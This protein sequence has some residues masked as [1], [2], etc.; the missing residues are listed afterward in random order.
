MDTRYMFK[1]SEKEDIITDI[2]IFMLHFIGE[3]LE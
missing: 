1:K 2:E 3:F